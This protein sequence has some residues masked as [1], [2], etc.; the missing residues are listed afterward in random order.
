N[1]EEWVR[2]QGEL[3]VRLMELGGNTNSTDLLSEALGRFLDAWCV[4]NKYNLP[5]ISGAAHNV[6]QLL[7][8][9]N[10]NLSNEQL[11]HVLQNHSASLK[12]NT[13]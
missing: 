4:A 8:D 2:R 3:A 9:L 7:T 1:P 11:K 12:N 6:E 5:S 10:K 13:K